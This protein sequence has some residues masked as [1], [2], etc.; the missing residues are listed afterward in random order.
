[1]HFDFEGRYFDTPSL[2]PAMSWRERLLL[3][4]FVHLLVVVLALVLPRL[5][6]MQDAAQRRAER[7]AEM[8]EEE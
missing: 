6:F 4:L 5:Q 7:L 3:S 1:M 2:E 8:V